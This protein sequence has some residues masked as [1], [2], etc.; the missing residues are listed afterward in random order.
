VS[1]ERVEKSIISDLPDS[2]RGEIWC[3]ICHVKRERNMHAPGFYSKLVEIENPE[4]EYRILKDVGRTFSNY[5]LDNSVADVDLTWNH[6][7]GQEM[8]FN[9]LIAYANYD[10]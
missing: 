3:M 1:K 2:L 7:K 9:I 6:E 4:D 5:P 10:S 8:L